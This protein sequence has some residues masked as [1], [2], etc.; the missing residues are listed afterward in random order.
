MVLGAG[1][2]S[3][4]LVLVA[5]RRFPTGFPKRQIVKP[6]QPFLIGA[7]QQTKRPTFQAFSQMGGHVASGHSVLP[8]HLHVTDLTASLFGVVKVQL[9]GVPEFGQPGPCV[10]ENW[11]V[12]VGGRGALF[13]KGPPSQDGL[14]AL[15]FME[16]FV[17]RGLKSPPPLGRAWVASFCTPAAYQKKRR[18]NN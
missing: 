18:S 4:S 6:H 2:P 12:V 16:L 1:L 15:G 13:P 7:R 3:S 14:A 5:L 17:R 10:F 8:F 11:I 9:A